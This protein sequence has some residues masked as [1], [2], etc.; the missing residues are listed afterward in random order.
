[1][2]HRILLLIFFFS[3][4]SLFAEKNLSVSP[5][6]S[7]KSGTLYEYL[8]SSENSNNEVS[9]LEW[10]YSQLYCL[11]LKTSFENKNAEFYFG[12]D[13]ALPLECGNMYDSDYFYKNGIKNK[14]NYSSSNN[15]SK[16]IF[17][18]IFGANYRFSFFERLSITP[19]FQ[20]QYTF[21]KFKAQ[22]GH[23]R[24]GRAPY[25][26]TG[27]DVNWDSEDAKIISK[28]YG[29]EFYRHNLYTWTGLTLSYDF[30]NKFNAGLGFFLS[31]FSYTYSVDHHLNK[32]TYDTYLKMEGHGNL[33]KF[34]YK[35]FSNTSI[36]HNLILYTHIEF[37]TGNTDKGISKIADFTEKYYPLDQKNGANIKQTDFTI[38]FK[39]VL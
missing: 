18:S 4:F 33:S 25:S 31:P 20:L 3:P 30:T 12:F 19:E 9:L 7:I 28:L 10:D 6:F 2:K 29:C 22:N 13:F 37:I 23:G 15:Y 17:N 38:G 26:K 16:L 39:I 21:A 24:Y 32:P 1:M 27:T 36:N 5:Y 35:L 8:Y 14:C 34:K 11:G